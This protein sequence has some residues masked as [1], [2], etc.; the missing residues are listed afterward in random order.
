MSDSASP[1]A[2]TAAG[3]RWRR[4]AWRLGA[5]ALAVVAAVA[6]VAY[7]ARPDS[8]APSGAWPPN[9]ELVPAAERGE[10]PTWRGEDV[11]AGKPAI[12]LAALKGTPVVLN[13]W[14]SWCGPCRAEQ[15]GLEQASTALAPA[16]VR[17]LGVNVRD[18]R[19]AATTYLAEFGVA[20]PSLYDQPGAFVQALGAD[21]P[22][23]PPT[24]LVVDASGRIA[25][26]VVG[27]LPGAGGDPAAQAA[28]LA[29]LVAAATG[30][31]V[32]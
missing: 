13:F 19:A 31:K 20:Y 21:A 18:D 24:T 29:K 9:V 15:R 8:A 10:L 25:A 1:A 17:F 23:A 26:R 7:L 5:A 6:A 22:T 16:G 2:S 30:A 14:A 28:E 11:R 12:D 3:P 4:P 27:T 32:S